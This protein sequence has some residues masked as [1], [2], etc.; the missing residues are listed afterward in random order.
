MKSA[1]KVSKKPKMFESL[2]EYWNNVDCLNRIQPKDAV[3]LKANETEADKFKLHTDLYPEPYMGDLSNPKIVFLFLNPGYQISDDNAHKNNE[4]GKALRNIIHQDFSVTEYPFFWLDENYR[5]ATNETNPGAYYWNRLVNQK[6][7][8]SFL[9]S[10]ADARWGKDEEKAR[11]WLAQNICDIEL[12]P[13]HSKSFNRKWMDSSS[14][15]EA[16]KAVIEAINKN[17]DTLFV[18]MR[19]FALWIPEEEQRAIIKQKTNVIINK[20]VRRP[21]LNPN[22]KPKNGEECIGKRILDFLLHLNQF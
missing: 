6:T 4:I 19:S 11:K 20:S 9:K 5:D 16:R 1:K 18:F 12:F 13:Y 7:G 8:T 3:F 15:S 22:I 17:S 10:F 21:S 14:V 2:V